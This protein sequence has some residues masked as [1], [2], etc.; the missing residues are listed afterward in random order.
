[1]ILNVEFL[2]LLSLL[3][4]ASAEWTTTITST[5]VVPN[6][7]TPSVDFTTKP[8]PNDPPSSSTPVPTAFDHALSHIEQLTTVVTVPV[9][10]VPTIHFSPIVNAQAPDS[11]GDPKNTGVGGGSGAPADSTAADAGTTPCDTVTSVPSGGPDGTSASDASPLSPDSSGADPKITTTSQGQDEPGSTPTPNLTGSSQPDPSPNHPAS[12]KSNAPSGELNGSTAPPAGTTDTAPSTSSNSPPNEPNSSADPPVGTTNT[13]PTISSSSSPGESGGQSAPPG[14]TTDTAPA[15]SSNPHPGESN[16]STGLPIDTTGAAPSTLSNSQDQQSTA[17]GYSPSGSTGSSTSNKDGAAGHAT[18]SMGDGPS[19]APTP[20]LTESSQPNSSP[21]V[22]ASS[23]SNAASDQPNTSTAPPADTTGTTPSDSSK[24]QDQLSTAPENSPSAPTGS[25][26]LDQNSA[27]TAAGNDSSSPT[28]SS[29]QTTDGGNASNGATETSTTPNVETTAA[30]DTS[31]APVNSPGQTSTSPPT[32]T[33]SSG[34]TAAAADTT[35]G[36]GSTA[37]EGSQTP[38][39]ETSM[40]TVTNLAGETTET[41]VVVTTSDPDDSDPDDGNPD[42]GNPDD[43][44]P[45]DGNPDDGSPDDGNPDDGNPDDGNPDDGNP[46]DGSPDDGNPDDGNPDDGNPDDGNPDDGNPD[47]G[48]PDDGNPDDGNPDD[49]NPDDGNPD[50]GDPD[51]GDPDDEPSTT[52]P[53]TSTTS[54]DSTTTPTSDA[55]ATTSESTTS[56][57]TTSTSTSTSTAEPSPYC[58]PKCDACSNDDVVPAALKN[59]VSNSKRSSST[60]FGKVRKYGENLVKRVLD[61]PSHADDL[62]WF[63]NAISQS[64]NLHHGTSALGGESSALMAELTNQPASWSVV[65]LYGCTSLILISKYGVYMS[66]YWQVPTF[67]NQITKIDANGQEYDTYEYNSDL[68]RNDVLDTMANGLPMTNTMTFVDK[69]TVDLFTREDAETEAIIFTPQGFNSPAVRYPNQVGLIEDKVKELIPGTPVH[70]YAYWNAGMPDQRIP[71]ESLVQ[72]MSWTF[73]KVI[74]QYDPDNGR[75]TREDPDTGVKCNAQQA[76]IQVLP[77]DDPSTP[78]VKKQWEATFE[79]LSDSNLARRDGAICSKDSYS[80]V[81]LTSPSGA[82]IGATTF[83]TSGS[84]K[85]TTTNS[86][87]KPTTGPTTTATAT[88]YICGNT[89]KDLEGNMG[90]YCQCSTPTGSSSSYAVVSLPYT[91]GS[92]TVSEQCY[93][94]TIMPTP[95]TTPTTSTTT[96]PPV[97]VTDYTSVDIGN[98]DIWVYP[99]GEQYIETNNPGVEDFTALTLTSGVGTA[100]RE[101]IN[102]FV[103][104]NG[105]TTYYYA[106]ATG[107]GDGDV[108]PVGEPTSTYVYTPAPIP[109][110]T[111]D[112]WKVPGCAIMDGVQGVCWSKCDPDTNELVG[113]VWREDDPWCWLMSEE[114]DMGV[115]CD[116]ADDDKCTTDLKCQPDTWPKGGCSTGKVDAVGGPI[117]TY[118]SPACGVFLETQGQ[119][120]SLCDNYTNSPLEGPWSEGNDWCWLADDDDS[121]V[122]CK[123]DSKCSDLKNCRS[124]DSDHGGC[125]SDGS[126]DPISGSL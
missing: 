20:N 118:A 98:G 35:D 106:E 15:T 26:T 60:W 67:E 76:A 2:L 81:E 18:T 27:T 13:P 4:E 117:D 12:S 1:M 104:T 105:E 74:V 91:M 21:S 123:E 51:D 69:I 34:E 109:T 30:T 102:D 22:P 87:P 68:F 113:S 29:Q 48:N 9:G 93:E 33:A 115:F 16:G 43:G 57:E 90:A 53:E 56:T 45:D 71:D 64:T 101:V 78:I 40:M 82:L 63:T 111:E 84:K 49:G 126:P 100:T 125:S 54:K 77:G 72:D 89:Q 59:Y 70:R 38:T 37:P 58:S 6:D 79:Q 17:P 120:W 99:T 32:D 103:S 110:P 83:R 107:N 47:D 42:D 46:D 11:S 50:D 10:K 8:P 73:G 62:Q 65:N 114:D 108:A 88:S 55:T 97:L 3:Q 39:T 121:M 25:S 41:P 28:N 24:S 124:T 66:H 95:T 86:S 92:V 116:S 44:N 96:D 23:I 52:A 7:R 5:L 14:G 119:C 61:T 80:T 31:A 122:W 36:P 75:K 94:I 19:T 85:L 112:M